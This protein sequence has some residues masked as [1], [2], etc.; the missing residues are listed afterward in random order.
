MLKRNDLKNFRLQAEDA[1]TEKW[2]ERA[3]IFLLGQLDWA[4]SRGDITVTEAAELEALLD[5]DGT[6]QETIE[7]VLTGGA[8]PVV[9]G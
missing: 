7:F 8:P 3:K 6:Y 5:P 2:P 1:V 4:V 9:K